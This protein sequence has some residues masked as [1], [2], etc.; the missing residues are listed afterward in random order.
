MLELIPTFPAFV[1]PG[2]KNMRRSQPKREAE[3]NE[4]SCS[5]SKKKQQQF[6][7]VQKKLPNINL[8]TSK[9]FSSKQKG[10][11]GPAM[12]PNL[13][14]PF[15]YTSHSWLGIPN[16]VTASASS[17]FS[18]ASWKSTNQP[19]TVATGNNSGARFGRVN[20]GSDN[21]GPPH[22]VYQMRCCLGESRESRVEQKLLRSFLI[23][24]DSPKTGNK[25]RQK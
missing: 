8:Q 21:A 4:S 25:K 9:M 10:A 18:K 13:S 6:H 7:Q 23:T 24:C 14:R 16:E 11:K 12:Y 15:K 22:L 19:P 2:F 20:P 17:D 3:N 1:P 5:A